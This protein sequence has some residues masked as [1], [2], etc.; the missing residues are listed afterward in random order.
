M[1]AAATL[2]QAAG[3]SF[4]NL[5]A[6]WLLHGNTFR[7]RIRQFCAT[8][9][10]VFPD[11]ETVGRPIANWLT[12]LAA[13]AQVMPDQTLL[14]SV[15]YAQFFVPANDYLYRLCWLAA[16]LSGSPSITTAQRNAILAE[17]N[18]VF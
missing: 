7:N 18:A 9:L 17:Y 16:G 3:Q 4:D 14:T 6:L 11:Q 15:D 8:L 12:V 13:L 2:Q 10:P 1:A 5:Y